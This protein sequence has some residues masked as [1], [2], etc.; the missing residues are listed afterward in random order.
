MTSLTPTTAS[1]LHLYEQMLRIRRFEELCLRLSAEGHIAGSIHPCLGQEAIPVGALTVLDQRDRVL[2]TYRGHGW[3]LACGTTPEA[4]LAEICGRATGVN[5]GRG[6]SA[7]LNDPEHRFLGE[8]SI[9]GGGVPIACGVA[10]AAQSIGDGG[11]ALVSFGD[12]ATSQGAVH[13]SMVFSAQRRLPLI[14]V[15]ENNGWSEMTPI[16]LV[17][18]V[19]CLAERARG[20]GIW[21]FTVDGDDVEAVSAAV[22]EASEHARSGDGPVFIECLTHRLAGHYNADTEHYRPPEDAERARQADPLARLR[23]TLLGRGEA[24]EASL[25]EVERRTATALEEA[26]KRALAA[27]LPAAESARDHIYA[28]SVSA[29]EQFNGPETAV[30]QSY[31]QAVNAGLRRALT[32]FPETLVFGEDVAIPGGVFGATRGLLSEFGDER[33]FDTPIAES[34]ILGAATGAAIRGLRP[35]AEIMW[36][37][38][39]LVALDQLVNQSANVRYLSRGRLQAPLVVRCQQGAAPGSCAQHSQSL[40]ALLA[41]VPGLRVGLPSNPNDA[42]QMLLAAVTSDDP[43]VLIESRLLYPTRGEVLVDGPIEPVGGARVRRTGDDLVMLTWG[44]MVATALEA[45]EALADDGIAA[46]VLDLRWLNPLD[47]NQIATLVR[48]TNRALVI[49][50]ANLRGGFGAEVAA[51]IGEYCFADLD[52]EVMRIATQNVRMPAAPSLQQALLPSAGLVATAARRL[53]AA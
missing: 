35:I 13:E 43:C 30:T 24:T 6:G 11:L 42:Y 2:A 4:L 52:A 41:H 36:A 39:L 29:D 20:Y 44:R 8:N 22:A 5:G 49:H 48:A 21:G 9:V 40:E 17:S 38:F 15:C 53:V 18:R 46:A 47:E 37:D 45:A 12:G 50:E 51:W 10:L 28:V 25:E 16:S 14:L 3:A 23:R 33:V 31:V 27:P 26:A 32:T 7:Y 1:L 19:G 34:A